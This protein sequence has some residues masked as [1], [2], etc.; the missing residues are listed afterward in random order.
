LVKFTLLFA[1]SLT[2]LA[3][4]AIAPAL[5][6]MLQAFTEVPNAELLVRLALTLPSLVIALTA[7]LAGFFVDRWGRK[8]ML[9]TALVLYALAG[10]SGFIMS[11]LISIL[12]GRTLLGLAVAGLMTSV[13]TLIS[14]Y[15]TDATRARLFGLQ[16]AFTGLGG[17][18]ILTGGGYLASLGWR[19][20]FLVYLLALAVL[21]FV[22]TT[23]AEPLRTTTSTHHQTDSDATNA[24]PIGMFVLIYGIAGVWQLAF[25]VIPSQL[26]FYLQ[27]V[28]NAGPTLSG[29][30]IAISTLF[31][32]GA[33]ATYSRLRTRATYSTIIVLA[34]GLMGVGYFLISTGAGLI[35]L[36]LGLMIGGFGNGL[37]L[38]NL[39][40]WLASI[41]PQDRRGR[42]L[43]GLTT[44]IFL[45]Q[46]LSPI[47]SEPISRQ[48]GLGATYGVFGG[49]LGGLA[50]LTWVALHRSSS[51][52]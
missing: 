47:V 17:V 38:P 31:G 30:A 14:D 49:A 36:V 15:Y 3:G 27:T 43:G 21:P 19:T 32:A 41:V 52:D 40:V 37:I 2:I 46:F 28:L 51:R 11:S 35:L 39:N 22:L 12:V 6:A 9:V 18:I 26:P 50:M 1:S 5:P 25:Y 10:S 34:F 29:F 45:G 44:T 16:A 48:I 33:S 13:T 4:A 8:P 23:I 20:P 7:P 24:L 42:A